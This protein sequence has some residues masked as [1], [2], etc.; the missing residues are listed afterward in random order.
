MY[1]VAFFFHIIGA[2]LLISG[3]VVAGVA[4]ETARRRPSPAEIALLLSLTRAGVVLVAVGSILAGGFGL[5]LVHL[6]SWG[7]GTGWVDASIALYIVALALGGF[8]GQ[9]PKQARLLAA[10][11]AQDAVPATPEL[12]ALLD[13]RASLAA[14]YTS[15]ALMVAIIALMCFK[16]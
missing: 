13:D 10:R 16:P 4:F 8:G 15:L 3:I 12:R 11:L 2:V 1:N 14:N 9:R 7:Y 5:W 6:G